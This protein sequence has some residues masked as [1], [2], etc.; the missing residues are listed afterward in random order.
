[1]AGETFITDV[2]ILPL[3][4]YDLI[5]GVEWMASVSPVTF[6]YVE[7]TVTI[8]TGEKVVTLPQ[9]AQLPRVTLQLKPPSLKATMEEAFFLVQVSAVEE[10]S[11]PETPR[12][13]IPEI[14]EL[15]K[16]YADIFAQPTQLPPPRKQD[17]H[18]P[19]KPEST[20]LNSHPYRCPIAHREEI[21]RITREMLNAGIIR[22]ST[23]PFV[24]P[25]L[26]VRK[27]DN[28]WRLVV[29]YRALNDLTIKNR[30]PILVIEELLSAL[31]GSKIYTKLDLRS[32]YHQ[33][34]IHPDDI[35]KT[36]F[37][38]HQGLFEFV[39]MPFGLTNA[40]ASFQELMNVVFSDYIRKF[41][42]V[43]FYDI[44]IFSSSLSEHKEHLKLVFD[45]LRHHKLFVKGS[46]CEFAMPQVEY[47]GHIISGKGVAA[48][49]K[50]I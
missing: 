16:D 44:L 5:L 41:V 22:T 21:E 36:V 31:Q 38:T 10:T 25:V 18:I 8:C 33:I 7:E 17:H 40:P 46:K 19:L 30:F 2:H 49:T 48:D 28:S 47:L 23:S 29:D 27:K 3:G 14:V 1:M 50:K 12:V 15:V 35:Y 26:L 11:S 34:K 45:K 42:L 13:T 6:N 9:T 32:G 24:S 39:V 20:L 37:R 43:F 4:G